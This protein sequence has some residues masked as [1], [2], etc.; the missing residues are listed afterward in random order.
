MEQVPAAIAVTVI[1][2]TEHALG[3]EDVTDTSPVPEPPVTLIVWLD[4]T[5]IDE[6]AV[7]ESA[8]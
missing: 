5:I 1:P 7:M 3:V 8:L 2:V 6:L 4:P